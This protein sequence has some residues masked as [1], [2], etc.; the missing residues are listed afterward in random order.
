MRVIFTDLD[1]TLLD[2]QTYSWAP[3]KPAIEE[4]ERRR[5]PW[6]LVTSKTLAEVEPLRNVLGHTHPFI[7]ENGA[8]AYVP[9]G[10]FPH[11]VHGAGQSRNGYDVVE[12][13][14]P[15]SELTKGLTTASEQSGCRVNGFHSMT[16]EAV[17]V[18]CELTP[19]QAQLAKRRE[20]DEP[21]L[22]LDADRKRFL[23]RAIEEKGLCWTR[24]GRFWHVFG[25]RPDRGPMPVGAGK[26]TAVRTMTEMFRKEHGPI[27]SI[28][29]GDGWNDVSFL[30]V[31]S[32]PVII[33]S[34]DADALRAQVQKAHV[35]HARGPEGWNEAV[36][37]L[38]NQ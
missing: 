14:V 22:I 13:G 3:A 38:L 1:G 21:F 28:G 5:I 8:A 37:G 9:R 25:W 18:E 11:L 23:L 32:R 17:A 29:L 4:L 19:E 36:I 7:V 35:T 27:Q 16:I 31:V 12:W 15:Y 33:R 10:Y 20:F 6:V 2:Q 34:K 24:G 30:K 26:G